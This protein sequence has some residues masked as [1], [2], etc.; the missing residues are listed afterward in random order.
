VSAGHAN[1]DDLIGLIDKIAIE[2]TGLVGRVGR[3]EVAYAQNDELALKLTE[4]EVA[5]DRALCEQDRIN[6]V[7]AARMG[8]TLMR[9]PEPAPRPRRPHLV[10]DN[11]DNPDNPD[12]PVRS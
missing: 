7:L 9:I 8:G 11:T 5:H 6:E 2:V 3:L 12:N 4:L 1:L 10:V